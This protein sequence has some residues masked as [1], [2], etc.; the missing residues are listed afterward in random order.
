MKKIN[1]NIKELINERLS[2]DYI[3]GFVHGDGG[4]TVQ[5]LLSKTKNSTKL[6]LLPMF[7]LTQHKRNEEIMK[8]IIARLGNRGS[9]S[10]DN[11]NIMRYRLSNIKDFKEELIPFF[12]KYQ[13]KKDKLKNYIKLK[14]I[15][16]KLL[17]IDSRF[18]WFS[19]DLYNE[20]NNLIL[21]LIIISVNMNMNVKSSI[22]IDKLSLK[23]K[24][25]VLK[26]EL[27]S[28]IKQELYD[29]IENYNY[30]NDLN[31]DFINGLFDSDGWITLRITINKRKNNNI[32]IG[33]EYGIVS[34]ILNSELLYEIKDY[35]NG[36]GSVKK[37]TDENSISYIITK[38]DFISKVLPKLYNLKN[39]EELENKNT[40]GSIIKDY[41][42]KVILNILNLYDEYKNNIKKKD[43]DKGKIIL[44]KILL[45]SYEIRDINLK[46]K[47]SLN[48]YLI[49]MKEK[50]NK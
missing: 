36:V 34:D 24:E 21:N 42:I 11:K 14:F 44:E 25:R 45:L 16:E 48:N 47:E 30:K 50:L 8:E 12:D 33:L 7:T 37:R 9:Y 1:N 23:D 22:N 2:N 35:F 10:I 46:N 13:L 20:Y 43:E 32:F 31:I 28:E 39:L 5:I 41:K 15:V 4:F 27:S 29:Y 40:K 38:T 3:A 17:T 18:R 26:N 6:K 49:R 19:Y